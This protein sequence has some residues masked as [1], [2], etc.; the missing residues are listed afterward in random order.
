M[1]VFF[2][3]LVKR[4]CLTDHPVFLRIIVDMKSSFKMTIFILYFICP[5]LAKSIYSDTNESLQTLSYFKLTM[6]LYSASLGMLYYYD[7]KSFDVLDME[8]PDFWCFRY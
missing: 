4:P 2:W 8:T 1:A 5:E 6:A 7:F 3:Y